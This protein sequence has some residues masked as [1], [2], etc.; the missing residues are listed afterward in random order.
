ML[1][2]KV[3]SFLLCTLL[4]FSLFAV[5]TAA[6]GAT[7]EGTVT[8]LWG[9]VDGDDALT[10]TDARLILQYVTEKIASEELTGELADVDGDGE[11]TT[12][13][14]RLVLQ[15]AVNKID[16]FPVGDEKTDEYKIV[17][18]TD[19]REMTED[20]DSTFVQDDQTVFHVETGSQLFVYENGEKTAQAVTWSSDNAEEII[21]ENDGSIS[22]A[23]AGKRAVITAALENGI[24]LQIAVYT[25]DDVY[26]IVIF[27]HGL[28]ITPDSD[29][30]TV[31]DGQP[32]WA[33]VPGSQLF[34]Y[35]NGTKTEKN[36]TWSS[37]NAEQIAIEEDGTVSAVTPGKRAI[38]TAEIE[39]GISLQIAV[40]TRTTGLIIEP[41]IAQV[42]Q[43]NGE[44]HYQSP[45]DKTIHVLLEDTQTVQLAYMRF[46]EDYANQADW[47]TSDPFVAT[48]D[49]KGCITLHATGVVMIAATYNGASDFVYLLVE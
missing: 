16:A 9:D 46:Y 7:Y 6:D 2:K 14:A 26:K 38:L 28:E 8:R 35:E 1:F 17:V 42:L 13:D 41:E 40:Y 47:E 31:I 5:P 37:D 18:F 20:S 44:T 4:L 25:K 34:V 11:V 3:F 24:S 19:D 33:V 39:N 36:V 29:N 22:D 21:V 30:A 45:V 48:V 15:Y 49:D 12:T 32:A 27:T 23:G 43:S 10:S